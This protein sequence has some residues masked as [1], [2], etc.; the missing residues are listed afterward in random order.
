[1]FHSL[2]LP[3]FVLSLVL[4]ALP[5]VSPE[6]VHKG[7]VISAGEGKISI[8]CQNAEHETFTVAKDA[9]ITRDG[10][11]VGLTVVV[12]GDTADVSTK[13]IEGKEFAVKIDARSKE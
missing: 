10:K 4:A 11:P 13:N 12:G 5:A 8:L 7:K 3:C 6:S 1:M 9:V 2:L